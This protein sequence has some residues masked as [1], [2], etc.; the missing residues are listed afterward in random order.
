M[1]TIEITKEFL[2]IKNAI[3]II[4]I[5]TCFHMMYLHSK[6]FTFKLFFQAMGWKYAF[7]KI[8]TDVILFALIYGVIYSCL[9]IINLF[10]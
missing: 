8:K 9:F 7:Y 4:G 3:C 2:N 1:E 10:N 6:S 5:T